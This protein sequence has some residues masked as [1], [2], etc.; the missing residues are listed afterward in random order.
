M[1]L[2]FISHDNLFYVSENNDNKELFITSNFFIKY[3]L[4]NINK[5]LY[6]EISHYE[7][8]YSLKSNIVEVIYNIIIYDEE[9]KRVNPFGLAFYYDLHIFCN[10]KLLNDNIFIES[11]PNYHHDYNLICIENFQLSEKVQLGIKIYQN[12]NNINHLLYEYQYFCNN[13]SNF[14]K[15]GK[16]NN[17][18]FDNFS[19]KNDYTNLIKEINGNNKTLTLK[20]SYIQKPCFY[21]ITNRGN[22]DNKWIF[23]NIYNRYF[24]FCKGLDCE[25]NKST[26]I[27]QICKYNYYLTI[28]DNYR[29]LYK[30][31]EYLL[32]DFILSFFNDDDILPIFKRMIAH[33]ISA[34]YMSPKN[35]LYSEFCSNNKRCNVIIKESYINGDFLEKYL[36]LILKLK[37][38][39]AGADFPAINNIFYN[40][41][42]ITSI[43]IGHGVKFFKAFLY[44][45]YT[46]PH[47][48]NKLVLSPSQKIISVAK[49][50]GWKDENIIKLCLPKWDKYYNVSP[51]MKENDKSIFVF[52]TWREIN[53]TKNL[54]EIS[55]LSISKFYINN[56]LLLLN[57]SKLNN[58]LN[59]KNITLFF[60]LHQNLMYLKDYIN[61]NFNFIKII[62]NEMISNC[63]LKSS[64]IISDFSSVIFDFIYQKKPVILYIPDYED[65]EIK[66]VYTNNYYNLIKS[67]GNGTIHFENQFYN[68]QDVVDKIIFYIN[69]NFQIENK[70]EKFYESFEFKC[71]KDNI[72]HF[73]DY[74]KNIK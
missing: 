70:L 1:I 37:V 7:T 57:N 9:N 31:T 19:L 64:L 32:A 74:I 44:K 46:S 71:K 20:S 27:F 50:Y 3:N 25:T 30:K 54:K 51:Q 59:K 38:T 68:S 63:L 11:F 24:C 12:N 15:L 66:D 2:I 41:E 67:V 18:K 39:V 40:I 53:M 61:K 17:Y 48:Y 55:K 29:D 47:K 13:N 33:N 34:H 10:I 69:N 65:P 62:K 23:K 28:I 21:T 22:E 60:G 45:D 14:F 73:I 5:T 56:I 6:F 4:D 49:N 36:E 52:F 42:Y 26:Y 35:D 16:K 58:E 8:S 43:N 72:Q